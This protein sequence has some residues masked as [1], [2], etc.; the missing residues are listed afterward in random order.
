MW[1]CVILFKSILVVERWTA[2]VVCL[3]IC[4]NDFKELITTQ[5][6]TPPKCGWLYFSGKGVVGLCFSLNTNTNIRW[7]QKVEKYVSLFSANHHFI[8]FAIYEC[9]GSKRN[10]LRRFLKKIDSK[11]QSGWLYSHWMFVRFC[12]IAKD[13]GHD[14]VSGWRVKRHVRYT[15][16]E[17][18]V[19]KCVP[20]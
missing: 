10:A 17:W 14:V 4:A 12:L 11:T 8:V 3:L 5:Q 2:H 16:T 19:Q 7:K 1:I 13:L 15:T 9:G 20:F 18:R 6:S